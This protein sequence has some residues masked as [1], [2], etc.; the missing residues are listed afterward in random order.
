MWSNGT[1]LLTCNL[2]VLNSSP[3]LAFHTSVY[4]LLNQQGH[5]SIVSHCDRSTKQLFCIC[6]VV[7][8]FKVLVIIISIV[9]LANQRAASSSYRLTLRIAFLPV[10][11]FNLS[12]FLFIT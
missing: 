3:L 4:S 5:S 2:D 11:F 9:Q 7:Y 12:N 10:G 6:L 8:L 1:K